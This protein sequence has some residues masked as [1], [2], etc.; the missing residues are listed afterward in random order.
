VGDGEAAAQRLYAEA[1]IT[2][3]PGGYLTRASGAAAGI[4]D[5][6][7]RLA[8]VHDAATTRTALERIR[9]TLG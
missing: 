7:L 3:L 2:A 8:L 4:G 6:Y 5:A 1:A 9:D